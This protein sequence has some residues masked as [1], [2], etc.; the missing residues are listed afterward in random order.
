M[1]VGL[2]PVQRDG[3]EYEFDLVCS[4]D[5]ENDLLVDKTR[6]SAYA[7]E[8]LRVAAKPT[9]EYFAPFIEEVGGEDQ[10]AGTAAFRCGGDHG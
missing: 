9:V 4:M 8:K 3:L 5:E 7:Q 1:K 2:A 10:H 6:C